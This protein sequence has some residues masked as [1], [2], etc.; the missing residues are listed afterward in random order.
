MCTTMKLSEAILLGSIGSEQGTGTQSANP[1]NKE[2]CAIGAAMLAVGAES[3]NDLGSEYM[4]ML[5]QYWPWTQTTLVPLPNKLQGNGVT[6]TVIEVYRL[7][8]RLND[9]LHW[10]RPQIAAWVATIEPQDGV[11]TEPGTLTDNINLSALVSK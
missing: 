9:T 3:P 5:R 10:T 2:L 7:I 6:G 4:G 8:W 1:H 11:V